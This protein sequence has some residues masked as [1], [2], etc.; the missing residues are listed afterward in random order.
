MGGETQKGEGILKH[1]RYHPSEQG[2][3]EANGY[4]SQKSI[5]ESYIKCENQSLRKTRKVVKVQTSL[6]TTLPV[7]NNVDTF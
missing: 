3:A 7:K 4:E 1:L 2:S 5:L 6:K